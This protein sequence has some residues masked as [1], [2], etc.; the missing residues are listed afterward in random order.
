MQMNTSVFWLAI[1]SGYH[2][3]NPENI[4][5]ESTK[6]NE[7]PQKKVEKRDI[8]DNVCM[9]AGPVK[10]LNRKNTKI[11]ICD[12]KTERIRYKW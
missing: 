7:R 12:I 3:D 5:Q 10:I 1:H 4:R 8:I 6:Q 2:S 11:K 9:G